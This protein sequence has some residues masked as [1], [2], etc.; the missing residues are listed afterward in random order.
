MLDSKTDNHDIDDDPMFDISPKA[1]KK[2]LDRQ[3]IQ[4]LER[5]ERL[6]EEKKG[7]ADD[8][9]DVFSEA[10]SQGYD[11]KMMR[12]IL[13]LRK[14]PVHDRKEMEAILEVYRAAVGID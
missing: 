14:M 1:K 5:I 10:K 7:I 9:K 3:L 11:A 4:F 8:E 13:T 6:R 12:H 2:A